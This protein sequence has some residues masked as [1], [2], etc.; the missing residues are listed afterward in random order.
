MTPFL[1]YEK[2][3]DIVWTDKGFKLFSNSYESQGNYFLYDLKNEKLIVKNQ[4]S[5]VKGEEN[6]AQ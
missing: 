2:K 1:Y 5:I 3:K 4:Q 6:S